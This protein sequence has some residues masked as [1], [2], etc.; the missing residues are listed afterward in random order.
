M[1]HLFPEDEMF[2][3]R[4]HVRRQASWLALIAAFALLSI[5]LPGPTRAEARRP[6]FPVI[7]ESVR[8]EMAASARPALS[9]AIAADGGWPA[10]QTSSRTGCTV[11]YATDGALALG[12]NN[13]DERNPL[14]RIWFVPGEAGAYGS[15]FVGYDDLVIQ[16]GMNEAGLFFDGLGVRDV[17][18]PARPGK[19][20]YT[21]Q[22]FFADVLSECDSVACVLEKLESVSMPG[23][24]NGQT[25]FG[26]RLGDSA[27]FEPL[28]VIAKSGRFQVATN[29]FQSEVPPAERTDDR[30]LTASEML[31]RAD[32]VSID[33]IRDVLN[34]THQ[35]GTVNTV[36]STIYDLQAQV[37]DLYYFHDFASGVRFDLKGELAK[38]VHGYDMAALFGSNQVA[39][40]RAAPIREAVMAKVSRLPTVRVEREGVAS[41][42]GT[43]EAAPNLTLRVAAN[44][45]GLAVR[46][47][48]TPWVPLVSLSTGEFAR[49]FSDAAGLVHEQRLRFS[50][51]GPGGSTQVEITDDQGAS[52]VATRAPVS[53]SAFASP[54]AVV[55]LVAIIAAA[56]ALVWSLGRL[57]PARRKGSTLTSSGE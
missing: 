2:G 31:T 46:L 7:D 40:D 12:G 17:D 42:E 5:A 4:G 19:P 10:G 16:G 53:R 55:G 28:A 52:V 1:I 23:T 21:G 27:I 51:S 54:Q 36:Y 35:E 9:S 18:V 6:T 24:W 44:G 41:I 34:A 3:E 45:D 56:G 37:I 14:T 8:A 32:E 26:D 57:P 50:A 25:L 39:A 13:E 30:Y 11:V 47:P 38:G 49:V 20:T 33:L 43:Y 48:W 29:F 22:D 15:V